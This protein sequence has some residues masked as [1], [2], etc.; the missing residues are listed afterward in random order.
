MLNLFI[1][2]EA[3]K[4]TPSILDRYNLC[5]RRRI[6]ADNCFKKLKAESSRAGNPNVTTYSWDRKLSFYYL[7]IF[8]FPD[9]QEELFA[10]FVLST[11]RA[12][13]LSAETVIEIISDS[14][15]KSD[16]EA[17]EL[18][19]LSV[20]RA[21]NGKSSRVSCGPYIGYSIPNHML[22]QLRDDPMFLETFINYSLLNPN[23]GSFWSLGPEMYRVLQESKNKI[24]SIEC[25][26]SPF[27]FN[28][29]AFCSAFSSDRKLKYEEGVRCYGDFFSYIKLLQKHEPPV[30]LICN[31]PYTDRIIDAVA[32]QI[33]TYMESHPL[34]EFIAILPDWT[35]QPGISSLRA[36]KG[37]VAHS[38]AQNE[39][40]F[41]DPIE[42]AVLPASFKVIA[43]INLGHDEKKSQAMLQSILDLLATE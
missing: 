35:E 26:A 22:D 41:W 37:S 14:K 1:D 6:W 36:L 18:P 10:S 17:T 7:E 25:F 31:P 3:N 9:A 27:N 43:V 13:G 5:V 15:R 4:K 39:F 33:V 2:M 24:T 32:E 38:F 42:G 19:P 8:N 16:L 30:R 20:E 28:L 29:K 23:T 11:V 12:F 40:R 34:G 21:S